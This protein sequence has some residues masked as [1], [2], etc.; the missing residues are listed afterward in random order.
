MG[1]IDLVQH[2]IDVWDTRPINQKPYR[3]KP[4]EVLQ[5]DITEKSVSP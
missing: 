4:I 5:G 3:L 2:N 1:R